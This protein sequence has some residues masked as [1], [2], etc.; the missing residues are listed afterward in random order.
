MLIVTG[1]LLAVGL[2]MVASTTVTLD[3]S[4]LT[5]GLLNSVFGRQLL[6][7]SVG[8]LTLCMVYKIT[9]V[10]FDS[11]FL[12]HRLTVLF[13]IA[14]IVCLMIAL[15]PSLGHAQRGSSRWLRLGVGSFTFGFQPSEPAK[16]ALVMM[17]AFILSKTNVDPSSFK[18]SFLPAVGVIGG[19]VVLVGI[20]DFGT[21][22]LLASV[23][24]LML[25]V[26]GSRLRD[27]AM[28]VLIGAIGMAGLLLSAPYR[29]E[30]VKAHMDIWSDPQ[31]AAYQPLQSMMTIASG[32]WFG[33]GLGSGLQKYGY[34]PEGHTDFIFAVICEETGIFGAMLV[35]ALF[36]MFI[37]IG[38][39][40]MLSAPNRF[41]RLLALGL[42]T[43]VA[44]QA[45]MN[46][47]VVTVLT[48]TTG[49]SLPFISA[50]GSGVVTFSIAVGILLAIAKR[51]WAADLEEESR[52]QE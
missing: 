3:R 27:L 24:G 1:T 43:T 8:L 4:F 50:G 52:Q 32:G 45:I 31:G 17:V 5:R 14:V 2:V 21:S 7:V 12:R 47:A 34:L 10:I 35:I 42:T 29:W 51:G 20:E 26:G 11:D 46:I 25:F 18:Q 41:E 6:Y 22:V 28:L 13:F 15:I 33:Q 49:I 44:L 9:P 39:R 19:C 40:I 37:W 36:A 48:P 38:L 16:L 23:G 30:R